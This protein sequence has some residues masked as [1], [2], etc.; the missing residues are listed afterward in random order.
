[1]ASK[2]QRI[3]KYLNTIFTDTK[4]STATRPG[5]YD[6]VQVDSYAWKLSNRYSASVA[7][8]FRKDILI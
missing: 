4:L 8:K 1:M 2:K 7:P 5:L 3:R 6:A